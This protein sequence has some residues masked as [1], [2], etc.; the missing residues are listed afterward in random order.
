[1]DSDDSGHGESELYYPEEE[2]IVE[3]LMDK[4]AWFENSRM[5]T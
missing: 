1:M 4:T 3:S 2:T 5:L